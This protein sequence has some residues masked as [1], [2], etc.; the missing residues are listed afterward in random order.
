MQIG[1]YQ[2]QHDL[3]ITSNI[4]FSHVCGSEN[5]QISNPN[6]EQDNG[7]RAS[8]RIAAYRSG[9]PRKRVTAFCS[10]N[11]KKEKTAK[12]PLRL[13]GSRIRNPKLSLVIF[14]MISVYVDKEKNA[15]THE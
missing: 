10:S 14:T 15:S 13:F 1:M 9:I 2:V 8:I 12:D 4:E 5:V 7:D 11:L 6:F 3:R